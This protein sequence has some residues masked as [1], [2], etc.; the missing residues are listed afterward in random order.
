MD[1]GIEHQTDNETQGPEWRVGAG[2]KIDCPDD[3]RP[4]AEEEENAT[5]R[6]IFGERLKWP[7]DSK[8]RFGRHSLKA[9]RVRV[10]ATLFGIFARRSRCS[11]FVVGRIS[12][13]MW[14]TRSPRAGPVVS[15]V[16]SVRAV[17]FLDLPFGIV[18]TSTPLPYV[19]FASEPSTSSGKTIS[20]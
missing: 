3:G 5:G 14:P 2:P 17:S 20:R 6:F 19:A 7:N 13:P 18:R 11:L 8:D 15:S 10:H 4:C 9:I 1:P 16:N 12:C